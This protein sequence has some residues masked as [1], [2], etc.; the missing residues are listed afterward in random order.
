MTSNR[1]L[2]IADVF[3]YKEGLILQLRGAQTHHKK[4][5]FTFLRLAKH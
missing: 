1:L 4:Y 2:L 5:L 3:T